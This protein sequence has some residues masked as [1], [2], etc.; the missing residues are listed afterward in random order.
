MDRNHLG[1]MGEAMT[2]IRWD[3]PYCGEVLLTWWTN[4]MPPSEV[5]CEAVPP[6]YIPMILDV[7]EVAYILL[8]W[9]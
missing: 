6:C 1:P 2:T 9:A 5:V 3:A 4:L 7:S 8:E